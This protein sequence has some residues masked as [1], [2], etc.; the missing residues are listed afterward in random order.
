M[1]LVAVEED[2]G[3]VA[4][5]LIARHVSGEWELEN[6]VVGQKVRQKGIGSRL[7]AELFSRAQTNRGDKIFLEVRHSNTAAHRLYE[8]AGFAETGRR[9]RYYSDPLE[10]AVLYSKTL[11]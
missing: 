10:D 3:E 7:L 1:I 8:K 5:F 2:S 9:K 4:G 11:G 6:I